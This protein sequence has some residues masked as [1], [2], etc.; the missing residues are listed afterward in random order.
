M[1][2]SVQQSTIATILASLP[3]KH[4]GKH[5][6]VF[7]KLLAKVDHSNSVVLKKICFSYINS[8]VSIYK[9]RSIFIQNSITILLVE[10]L[11]CVQIVQ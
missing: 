11:L 5:R 7:F 1:S 10:I 4:H 9:F 2:I 3:S 6:L 8:V